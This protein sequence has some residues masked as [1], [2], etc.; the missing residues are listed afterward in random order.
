MTTNEKIV[1]CYLGVAAAG[2]FEAAAKEVSI[3][4]A[5]DKEVKAI[6]ET[7]L[8]RAIDIAHRNKDFEENAF[9]ASCQLVRAFQRLYSH[10]CYIPKGFEQSKDFESLWKNYAKQV[11]TPAR[12]ASFVEFVNTRFNAPKVTR[13][14]ARK[15]YTF[16]EI[17][18]IVICVHLDILTKDEAR[19]KVRKG[20]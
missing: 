17:R 1:Q 18:Q 7:L 14:K 12:L 3:C 9:L 6:K 13:T 11:D 2:R 16:A 19:K 15:P 8:K 20:K 10:S 4:I 5:N